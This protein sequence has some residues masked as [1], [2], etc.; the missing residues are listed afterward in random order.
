MIVSGSFLNLVILGLAVSADQHRRAVD[1]E[2]PVRTRELRN[3]E[4]I[5]PATPEA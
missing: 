1:H 4:T 3:S 2:N 5:D